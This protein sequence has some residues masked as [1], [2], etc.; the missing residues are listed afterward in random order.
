MHES[1][2]VTWSRNLNEAPPEADIADTIAGVRYHN[3]QTQDEVN[4]LICNI[5]RSSDNLLDNALDYT[6]TGSTYNTA[7]G[8][9][10][11]GVSMFNGLS[12]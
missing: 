6:R 8:I 12:L 11:S 10:V 4:E 5:M 1:M 3:P 2:N 7:W 9:S